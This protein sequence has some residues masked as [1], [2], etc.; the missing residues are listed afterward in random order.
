M[1][2]QPYAARI[3]AY[4]SI[5]THGAV[6]EADPHQLI[7]MLMDGALDR[8]A[9]AKGC[10]ERKEKVQKAALLHRVVAII[11]ELRASL[12]HNAGGQ[13]AANLENLYEYIGRRVMTANLTD[14]VKPIDESVGLLQTIRRAWGAIPQ[15]ARAPR[16]SQP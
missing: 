13:V 2:A 9:A 5:S 7:S 3:A 14:D 15:E 6:A 4:K 12:D 1:A 11:E 8:M 10:I 16:P